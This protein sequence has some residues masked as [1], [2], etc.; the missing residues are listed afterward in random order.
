[1]H[2]SLAYLMRLCMEQNP[3]FL[4][5]LDVASELQDYATGVRHLYD[6]EIEM[7]T[8]QDAESAVNCTRAIRTFIMQ[9]L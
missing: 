3:D 6:D 8:R 7:L 4:E 2:N 1:M 9:R 5:L